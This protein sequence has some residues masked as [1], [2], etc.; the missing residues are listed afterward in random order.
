MIFMMIVMLLPL[1]ALPIFWLVPLAEAIPIY[2]VCLLVWGSMMWM[3]RASMKRKATTG[4][5]SLI[6]K[7]AEVISHSPSDKEAPYQV[8]LQGEIWRAKSQESLTQGE[9][10]AIV[11]VEGNRLTVKRRDKEAV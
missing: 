5:E 8:R 4:I 7:Q 3:M 2:A 6:G 1:I 10:V 11:A 9:W